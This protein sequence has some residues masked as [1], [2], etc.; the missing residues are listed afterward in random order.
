[1]IQIIKSNESPRGKIDYGVAWKQPGLHQLYCNTGGGEQKFLSGSL[2]VS[3]KKPLPLVIKQMWTWQPDLYHHASQGL[4]LI[5]ESQLPSG[6]WPWDTSTPPLHARSWSFK[7]LSPTH[8]FRWG[9][10]EPTE[11]WESE[12]ILSCSGTLVWP[13]GH[14]G[15]ISFG[16]Y[17]LQP[18]GG[19]ST[20]G[21]QQDVAGS[22][23]SCLST[24]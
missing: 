14:R 19:R 13:W 12:K 24:P 18:C 11:I 1:M 15:D 9:G 8:A 6:P 23:I 22:S 5:P 10:S 20:R 2:R 7:G 17:L 21:H 4:A 3:K 16:C